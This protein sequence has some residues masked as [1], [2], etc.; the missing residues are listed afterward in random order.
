MNTFKKA[1]NYIDQKKPLK[2]T[3]GVAS[4]AGIGFLY[5]FFIGCN[6]GTCPLTSNPVNS[7]MIGAAMGF[8]WVFS[9][10][11]TVKQEQSEK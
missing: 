10:G 2:Y 6:T 1:I 7:M 8:F 5:Y 11:K 3:L 9:P 4:G